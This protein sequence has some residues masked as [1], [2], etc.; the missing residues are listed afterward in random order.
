LAN[1]LVAGLE[2]LV[3]GIAEHGLQPLI[4]LGLGLVHLLGYLR[5]IDRGGIKSTLL[6]HVLEN[7]LDRLGA[8]RHQSV[9]LGL[10]HRREIHLGENVPIHRRRHLLDVLLHHRLHLGGVDLDLVDTVIDRRAIGVASRRLGSDR[11]RLRLARQGDRRW[12]R[13]RLV[14]IP[15]V[16]GDSAAQQKEKKNDQTG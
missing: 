5:G 11:H 16:T 10:L 2:L 6:K 4:G 3:I 8:L 13:D 12:R 9:D 15:G 14:P 1:L 7:A